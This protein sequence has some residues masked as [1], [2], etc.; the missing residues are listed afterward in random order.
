MKPAPAARVEGWL[1]A[2]VRQAP[3]GAAVAFDADGTLWRGD[4]GEDFLRAAAFA[5]HAPKNAYRQYEALLAVDLATAYAYCA[6]VLAGK[7]EAWLEAQ[8]RQFFADRFEGR[9]F[10]YVRPL[11]AQLKGGRLMPWIVS[12]SPRWLVQAG[13]R[14]LGIPADHVLAVSVPV[15]DGKLTAVAEQPVPCGPGKAAALA[16]RGVRPYLA[17]GN[18]AIDVELLACAQHALVVAPRDEE[19]PLA[20]LAPGRGWPILRV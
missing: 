1:A 14:A 16:R 2:R 20:R 3:P 5:G 15:V 10:R 4:V 13:A 19:T 7:E 8:A 9:V 6:E 12:A 18:G 11:L 17:L